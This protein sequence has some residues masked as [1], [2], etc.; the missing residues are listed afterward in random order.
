MFGKEKINKTLHIEGMS[1]SHCAA[2]VEKKL[3]ALKGVSDVSVDLDAKTATV[4]LR[5]EIDNSLLITAVE[6]AGFTVT[7]IE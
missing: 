7:S 4:K 2:T 5:K 1:C 3:S 6:D